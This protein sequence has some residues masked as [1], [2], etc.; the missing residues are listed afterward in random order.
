MKKYSSITRVNSR[1]TLRKRLRYGAIVTAVVLI[2]GFLFPKILSTVSFVAL[3]PVHSI[4]L[5]YQKSEASL[6]KYLRA[7]TDLINQIDVLKRQI[8]NE[9]ATNL[10]VRRLEEENVQLRAATGFGKSM[11]RIVARVIAQPNK[12]SYDLLQ[13]DK[14]ENEGI[15]V[16]SLVFLGF[17]TVIGV[18]VHTAPG[19]S[20]IELVTSPGFESTAY[21]VGPN[22]F[23]V[24]EGVGGGVARVRVPQGISIKEGNLVILP[25]I[26]SGVYGEIVS[27]ENP[28][29]QPVQYGYVTPPVSLQSI[30]YVSVSLAE[31]TERALPDIEKDIV[32]L[33]KKY[34][35]LE[36]I[37]AWG[38][39]VSG[40]TTSSSTTPKQATSS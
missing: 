6:P 36:K 17:D 14:G 30:M 1:L 27:I 40:T 2:V 23:T 11:S 24:L 10:S 28:P 3:Y 33:N 7:Q 12:L 20:F 15:K 26:E 32:E 35:R 18:V 13:I 4:S 16:G 38:S 5:W 21:V 9:T 39:H 29:T 25:S 22:V 31:P 34:F 8:A 19:Y 37:P